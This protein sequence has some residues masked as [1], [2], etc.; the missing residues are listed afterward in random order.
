[1]PLTPRQWRFVAEYVKDL[2]GTKAAIRAGYSAKSADVSASRLLAKAKVKR[3]VDAVLERRALRVE[4]KQ[5][6]VVREL[7]AMAQTD[8]RQAFDENG[9]LRPL[10]EMPADVAKMISGVETE[11]LFEYVGQGPDRERVHVGNVRKVKFWSKE[12]ALELLGRH[13]KMFTDKLELKADASFADMLKKARER[14]GRK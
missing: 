12:K 5:D 7:L 14:A 11:E 1:M 3:E 2:N 8:M 13:L 4:V 10:H 9:A 6:D